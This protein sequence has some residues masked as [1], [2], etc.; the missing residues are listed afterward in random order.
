[1]LV[2]GPHMPAW[3]WM[4]IKYSTRAH[5]MRFLATIILG[6]AVYQLVM[7]GNVAEAWVGMVGMVVGYYFRGR[8]Q[9][10]EDKDAHNPD[11]SP[12]VAIER[13]P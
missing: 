8:E 5:Y 1:M 12:T 4:L 3:K 9:E 10:G 2:R 7:T 6:V 11:E 13:K